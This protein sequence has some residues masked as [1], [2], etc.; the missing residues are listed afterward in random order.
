MLPAASQISR[1]HR[2]GKSVVLIGKDFP[3]FPEFRIGRKGTRL[4]ENP[5][6]LL[7]RGREKCT[8]MG[9]CQDLEVLSTPSNCG[10]QVSPL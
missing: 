8:R 6:K 3:C 5:S 9:N 7:S 1:G 4:E 10:L 2:E